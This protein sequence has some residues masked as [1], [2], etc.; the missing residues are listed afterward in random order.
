MT[1]TNLLAVMNARPLL[2]LNPIK[3]MQQLGLDVNKGPSFK[4]MQKGGKKNY[5]F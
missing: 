5:E 1:F 2:V 4:P 3:L